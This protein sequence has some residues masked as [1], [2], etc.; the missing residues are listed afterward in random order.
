MV[1][2]AAALRVLSVVMLVNWPLVV[3]AIVSVLFARPTAN[4]VVFESL[5]ASPILV[6]AAPYPGILPLKSPT[7]SG[8]T[9][10]DRVNGAEQT[11]A[12]TWPMKPHKAPIS[13]A[14]MGTRGIFI[15]VC[16]GKAG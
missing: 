9:V 13:S 16:T 14:A 15:I 10:N 7:S 1:A 3:D 12:V 5:S 11:L 6:T 8:V 2:R 4:S